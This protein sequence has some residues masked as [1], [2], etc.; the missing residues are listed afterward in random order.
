VKPAQYFGFLQGFDGLLN[1]AKENNVQY[2]FFESLISPKLSETI[3][4]EVGAKT[5]TLD[6]IEGIA[7]NDIKQG[8]D[9]FTVM[10]QNLKSLQLALQ[11]S[12]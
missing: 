5:L 7:D 9:Y 12:I 4:S 6:P 11:C 2:I 1:F 3:A 8:K 10:Q